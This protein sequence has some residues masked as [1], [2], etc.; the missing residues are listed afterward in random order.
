MRFLGEWQRVVHQRN[1]EKGFYDYKLDLDI[2]HRGL[3]WNV[4]L[5]PNEAVIWIAALERL[6]ADYEKAILERKLL[7]VIGEV[8][9]A[10]EEL[11]KGHKP[12]DVYYGPGNPQKPEGFRMEL[13]DSVIR[14]LDVA[15]EQG[16][17]LDTDMAEKHEFNGTRPHKHGK[18]F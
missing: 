13:A 2:V 8:C 4:N 10:H 11:R 7:L 15:Q 17:D 3:D 14:L 16:I 18:T 9:E 1:V 6:L 5:T 12:T